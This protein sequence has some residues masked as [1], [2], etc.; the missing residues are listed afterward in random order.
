[1]PAGSYP[2]PVRAKGTG[3]P[4]ATVSL[5]LIVIPA[6]IG[7]SVVPPTT[8]VFTGSATTTSLVVSRS[9]F[10]GAVTFS[11]DA[12]PS[13]VTVTFD[14]TAIKGGRA[15]VTSNAASGAAAGTYSITFRATPFGLAA[16][17]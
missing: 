12:L 11:A 10:G 14:S 9:N 17:A 6:T 15:T 3:A 2:V 4:D 5:T 8:S 16:A 1:T 7:L 13:G